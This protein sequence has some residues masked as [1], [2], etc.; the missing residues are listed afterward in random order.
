MRS[1]IIL[2][3]ASS[4]WTISAV[5]DNSINFMLDGVLLCEIESDLNLNLTYIYGRCASLS[6]SPQY[7]IAL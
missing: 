1:Y 7:C 3:F 6:L 2:S 4:I 5:K